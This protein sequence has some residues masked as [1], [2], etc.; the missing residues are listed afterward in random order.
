M[1]ITGQ[2]THCGPSALSAVTGLES[3]KCA[4]AV[5]EY[6]RERVKRDESY[7]NRRKHR[8]K[9]RVVGTS[10]DDLA[11][12]LVALGFNPTVRLYG[13]DGWHNTPECPG[14]VRV[15]GGVQTFRKWIAENADAGPC[16]VGLGGKW[17]GHWIAYCRGKVADTGYLFTDRPSKLQ[18]N[19]AA[20]RRRVGCVIELTGGE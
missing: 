1:R 5:R 20:L 10:A 9:G 14:L 18:E 8:V 4:A 12:A 19:D 3:H 6:R 17:N 13:S 7:R 11:G 2:S 16:V 15:D